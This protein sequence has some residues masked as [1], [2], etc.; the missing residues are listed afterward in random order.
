MPNKLVI[1]TE[2]LLVLLILSFLP[3]WRCGLRDKLTFWEWAREHTIWGHP[4]E[5]IPEEDYESAL[6]EKR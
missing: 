4:V 2:I 1:S 6:K 3:V 5:Y